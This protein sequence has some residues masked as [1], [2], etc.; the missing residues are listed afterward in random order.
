MNLKEELEQKKQYFENELD[1]YMPGESSYPEILFKSMRYSLFA[2]GKRLRPIMLIEACEAFGG[3]AQKAMPFA[4]AMEMIHTYSLIH[5]DLPALDNDN[6][7]RGRLT[8]HKAFGENIAILAGDG[9]LSYA[10]EIMSNAV[11]ENLD[12]NSAKA[13]QAVAFAAGVNGMVS[14]QTVDV[15]SEGKKIDK[16]TLDFIHLNKTAAMIV[17]AVKAGA[18]LGGADEKTIEKLEKAAIKLG[19][20]FQ[21]QD[22]VLDVIGTFDELG[23]TTNSDEKNDKVTYVSL[24]GV[25]ESKNFT[26]KLSNE[27][28]EI[29]KSCGDNMDFFVELTKYLIDRRS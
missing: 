17:G 6:F 12:I 14:G 28:I 11:V 20:A 3:D 8:N 18:Y 16:Q 25:E 9:L 13:M 27:A 2:G 26:E 4:C 7:R 22:D 23:K 21:I 24:F 5:D 29:F 10:F 1:K 19:I 15:I